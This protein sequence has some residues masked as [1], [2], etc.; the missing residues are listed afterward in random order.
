[1]GEL[2]GGTARRF[3]RSLFCGRGGRHG[4]GCR[5]LDRRVC[6]ALLSRQSGRVEARAIGCAGCGE[7]GAGDNPFSAQFLQI[8]ICLFWIIWADGDA[9][10][11][12]INF[13]PV[14]IGQI[15]GIVL[16]A[17]HTV[18]EMQS[19]LELNPNL[20]RRSGLRQSSLCVGQH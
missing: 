8:G 13:K 18:L 5:V 16:N 17:V 2:L 10:P 4:L 7:A 14:H 15:P 11:A 20:P 9:E 3:C 6:C 19:G 12:P 1:M